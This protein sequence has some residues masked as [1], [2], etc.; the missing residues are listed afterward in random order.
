M[1]TVSLIIILSACL[2]GSQALHTRTQRCEAKLQ[3]LLQ[4]SASLKKDCGEMGVHDCCAVSFRI[5]PSFKELQ[6]DN[7]CELNYL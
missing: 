4:E 1:I 7:Q 3:D 5:S 6:S 2:T